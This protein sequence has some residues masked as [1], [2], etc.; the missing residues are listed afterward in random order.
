MLGLWLAVKTAIT[1]AAEVGCALVDADVRH[2]DFTLCRMPGNPVAKRHVLVTIA[3]A[4][5]VACVGGCCEA[6]YITRLPIACPRFCDSTCIAP[7]G[8]ETV[9]EAKLITAA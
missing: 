1:K 3:F 8:E 5:V 6:V 9:R 7:S 4:Q 2:V